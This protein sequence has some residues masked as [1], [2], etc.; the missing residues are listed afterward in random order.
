MTPRLHQPPNLYDPT[1]LRARAAGHSVAGVAAQGGSQETDRHERQPAEVCEA[2]QLT[3]LDRRDAGARWRPSGTNREPAVRAGSLRG[4]RRNRS[5]VRSPCS[6]RWRSP[7]WSASPPISWSHTATGL[8]ADRRHELTTLVEA[9]SS[10]VNAE[11]AAA[12]SGQESVE[13]AQA[14]AE[15]Q[16]ARLRYGEGDYVWINDMQPRM[17]MHP[18]KPEMNGQDLSG[19]KDPNGKEAVRRTDGR[20]RGSSV[21]GSSATSGRNPART[22]RSR[23][24]P[25]SQNSSPGAG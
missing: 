23:S 15:K 13:A 5:S 4:S 10:I 3:P 16:L 14:N 22:S 20:R 18:I 8:W 2:R 12:Q 7:V 24:C 25:M 6:T 21:R 19:Y 1:R 17:V 11:Y 9:A